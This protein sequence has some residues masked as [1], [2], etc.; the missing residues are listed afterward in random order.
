MILETIVL[1][2]VY[3]FLFVPITTIRIID[4]SIFPQLSRISSDIRLWV[5]ANLTFEIDSKG[6]CP[7]AFG[8]EI[9]SLSWINII[10]VYLLYTFII[11]GSSLILG[12]TKYI[13]TNSWPRYICKI[14]STK[15]SSFFFNIYFHSWNFLKK[16]SGNHSDSL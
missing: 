8:M 6:N 15:K 3:V 4:N 16:N 11:C 7:C 10:V 14:R 9:T 13:F 2:S 1:P 5:I 12:I